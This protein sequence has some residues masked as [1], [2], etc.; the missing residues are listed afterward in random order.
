MEI[1][2]YIIENRL[3]LIPVL[4]IIGEFIKK[5]KTINNRWIPLI[6]MVIGVVFSILMGGD[7]IINNIIQGVLVSGVTVLGNQIIK[8]I[9]KDDENE[10]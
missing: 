3:I 6:L 8:Q 10:M 7:K 1:L 2:N 5:T 9:E 4:Y